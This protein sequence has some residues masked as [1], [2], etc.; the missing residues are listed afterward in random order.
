MDDLFLPHA[1]VYFYIG[2][3]FKEN[4]D[5]R[6]NGTK[7]GFRRLVTPYLRKIPGHMFIA[8]TAGEDRK[9]TGSAFPVSG[10]LPASGLFFKIHLTPQIFYGRFLS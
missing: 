6:R 7:T 8:V 2:L 5:F 3:F 4:A 9:N 10:R 1:F